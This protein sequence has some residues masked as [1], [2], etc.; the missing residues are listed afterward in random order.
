[1]DATNEVSISIIASTL[2]LLAVFIPLTM[3]GGM[4]VKSSASWAGSWLSSVP[5]QPLPTHPD[6]MMS[7]QLQAKTRKNKRV[8]QIF[9]VM[10]KKHWGALDLVYTRLWIGPFVRGLRFILA[11][12]TVLLLRAFSCRLFHGIFPQ[13][14]NA[15]LQL[16]VKL[17]INTRSEL[18]RVVFPHSWDFQFRRNYPEIKKPW[19]VYCRTSWRDG[20]RTAER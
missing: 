17:P 2:T 20:T 18:Q 5:S 15:R 14:D 3:V 6:P 4:S 10:L 12:A 1:M 13:Q 7:S 16:T 9:T 8:W 19:H 11:S